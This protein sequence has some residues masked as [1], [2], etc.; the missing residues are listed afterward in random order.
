MNQPEINQP[1]LQL[2]KNE[3]LK[4]REF[5]TEI[6]AREQWI[7]Q[8]PSQAK[9]YSVYLRI[10][11]GWLG[12]ADQNKNASNWFKRISEYCPPWYLKDERNKFRATAIIELVNCQLATQEKVVRQ[13]SERIPP[14]LIEEFEEKRTAFRIDNWLDEDNDVFMSEAVENPQKVLGWETYEEML[15]YRYQEYQ[16]GSSALTIANPQVL[17]AELVE[18]EVNF[19][20]AGTIA[21]VS[22][23]QNWMDDFEITLSE[24]E[25]KYLQ[26]Q[27]KRGF[28]LGLAGERRYRQGFG[29]AK[30]MLEDSEEI[31]DT[32]N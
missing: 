3:P 21:Q 18:E 17:S 14:E 30:Q 1:A 8:I 6:T 24:R 10:A 27:E 13:I 12:G 32:E 9:Y 5:S 16:N 29:K 31:S 4:L 20:N 26:A 23:L 22:Q 7:Y 19:N 2:V 25:K 15:S 11:S 28:K